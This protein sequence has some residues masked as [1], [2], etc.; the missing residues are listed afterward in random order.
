MSFS[1]LVTVLAKKT[2]F[3]QASFLVCKIYDSKMKL[4]KRKKKA[5]LIAISHKDRTLSAQRNAIPSV[6]PGA[7]ETNKKILEYLRLDFTPKS[8]RVPIARGFVR[9]LQHS[10]DTSVIDRKVKGSGL[11]RDLS[12]VPTGSGNCVCVLGQYSTTRCSVG[13]ITTAIPRQQNIIG[14]TSP[15]DVHIVGA[16]SFATSPGRCACTTALHWPMAG[17]KSPETVLRAL[18]DAFT[19]ITDYRAIM[20]RGQIY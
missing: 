8:Y 19:T 12:T 6:F 1:V 14:Q 15:A 5:P 3:L 9:W 18:A 16:T 4:H 17:N 2:F 20:G 10:G 13:R 11:D 7:S